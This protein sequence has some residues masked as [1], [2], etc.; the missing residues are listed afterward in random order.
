V[1]ILL[2]VLAAALVVAAG[3]ACSGD[4][5]EAGD[6]AA[7]TTSIDPSE[8]RP[9]PPPDQ[10]RWA[11][12]V[13]EACKDWQDR[14][15]AV[16]PPEDAESLEAWVTETLPLLR[17]QIEAVAEV[18]PSA[19]EEEVRRAQLFVGGLSSL[20]RAL[21]RYLDAIRKENADAIEQALADASEAGSQ[22]RAYAISLDVTQCG[23]YSGD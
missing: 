6:T 15:D 17:S 23:G 8:Q 13:D 4:D 11:K 21:T 12:E 3:T 16:P 14:I 20:E 9:E 5:D 18:R 7:A 2:L 10:S 1:R 22:T 19:K